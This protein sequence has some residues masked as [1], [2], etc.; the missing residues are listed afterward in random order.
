MIIYRNLVVISDGLSLLNL[1]NA[2][3]SASIFNPDMIAI[4]EEFLTSQE[5]SS[6]QAMVNDAQRREAR[7]SKHNSWQDEKLNSN[8]AELTFHALLLERHLF[9]PHVIAVGI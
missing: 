7:A 3:K 6:Q 9:R 8:A 1:V 5:S 4:S 2:S